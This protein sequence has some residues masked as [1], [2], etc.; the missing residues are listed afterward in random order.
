[1]EQKASSN[2]AGCSSVKRE[3]QSIIWYK[4]ICAVQMLRNCDASFSEVCEGPL[5]FVKV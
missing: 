3:K 4:A 1:M 2:Q 5:A